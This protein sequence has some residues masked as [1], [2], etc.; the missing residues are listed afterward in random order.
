MDKRS[1]ILNQGL[2][3]F[4]VTCAECGKKAVGF[5]RLKKIGGFMDEVFQS[6]ADRNPFLFQGITG[7]QAIPREHV[8]SV[9]SLLKVGDLRDLN[10]YMTANCK[11][12]KGIDAYC[13]QCNLVYCH[14]HYKTYVIYAHDYPG[15]YESTEGTCP[16]GH[17]RSI[18]D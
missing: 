7:S 10:N 12:T 8:T 9:V 11:F 4:I 1:E 15:W 6:E 13:Y 2:K 14:E 16:Q 17:I 3:G 18:D 5:G